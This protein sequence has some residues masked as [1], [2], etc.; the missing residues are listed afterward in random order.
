MEVVLVNTERMEVG[1]RKNG[2]WGSDRWNKLNKY[3]RGIVN[4]SSGGEDVLLID[5]IG[6]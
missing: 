1:L 5:G 4:G 6:K 2:T 3:G